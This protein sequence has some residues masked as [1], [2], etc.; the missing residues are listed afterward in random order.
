MYISSKPLLIEAPDPERKKM[1][2]E[3]PS[4]ESKKWST[5]FR[6]KRCKEP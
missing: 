6:G 5:V 3:W 4:T 2:N 1:S